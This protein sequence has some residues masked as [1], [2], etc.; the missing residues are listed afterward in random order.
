MRE[1]PTV[2][3][4][5]SLLLD[6]NDMNGLSLEVASFLWKPD[7]VF[8]SIDITWFDGARPP[9]LFGGSLVYFTRL[10]IR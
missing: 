2:S 5:L 6:C 9:S 3:R 8:L 4:E 7:T 1:I 10:Q